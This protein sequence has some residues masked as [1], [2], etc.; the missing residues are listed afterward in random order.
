MPPNNNQNPSHYREHTR[1]QNGW[2]V[3]APPL[4]PAGEQPPPYTPET[5][6]QAAA[7]VDVAATGPTL[8]FEIPINSNIIGATPVTHTKKYGHTVPFAAAYVEICT[9]MGI[10]HSTAALGYK[11]DNESANVPVHGLA[12]A[13]NRKNCLE[14]RIGQT[15]RAR[16]RQVTC[17]VKNLNPPEETAL[18]ASKPTGSRKRKGSASVTRNAANDRKTFDHTKEY[19][20]LEDHLK[21]AKHRDLC[22]VSSV[23]GH[24][25]RVSITENLRV[26]WQRDIRK[27]PNN[28]V[29]Q[30]Y[31]LRE[32]DSRKPVPQKPTPPVAYPRGIALVSNAPGDDHGCERQCGQYPRISLPL[33]AQSP[34]RQRHLRRR[35]SHCHRSIDDSGIFK[36]SPVLPF[37]AVIF[38]DALHEFEITREGC[39][40]PLRAALSRLLD[41]LRAPLDIILSERMQAYLSR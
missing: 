5:A 41:N 9:M 27:P 14:S 6:P 32:P 37:P 30:E 33:S 15:A 26:G 1:Q 35:H 36:D 23:D 3:L 2:T 20:Q 31:F 12:N 19:R 29:F 17:M 25:H 4:E 22:Y 38:A 11:W 21:C 40:I 10:D 8:S 39:H 24:H 34:P 28:I 13:T 7:P 16:T 18:T